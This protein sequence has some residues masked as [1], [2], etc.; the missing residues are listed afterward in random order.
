MFLN[1]T[2]SWTTCTR[3]VTAALNF[4]ASRHILT[5][6]LR[7]DALETFA[8]SKLCYLSQILPMPSQVAQQLTMAAW[9]FLWR[10]HFERLA[11]Q[12]LH[13]PDLDGGLGV[14]SIAFWA[15]VLLS[16]QFC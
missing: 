1:V 12:E 13:C 3:G 16:E 5:L 6:R 4:W 9:A 14:S 7:R 15:Q 8:L 2:A 11:W 10:G